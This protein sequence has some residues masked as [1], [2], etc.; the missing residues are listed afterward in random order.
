M[1]ATVQQQQQRQQQQQQRQQQ[2]QQQQQ[3]LHVARCAVDTRGQQV[4]GVRQFQGWSRCPAD[5][6]LKNCTLQLCA[7]GYVWRCTAID[8]G[9]LRSLHSRAWR[10]CRFF[11]CTSLTHGYSMSNCGSTTL[12]GSVIHQSISMTACYP[13]VS[14]LTENASCSFGIQATLAELH[15]YATAAAAGC[16]RCQ[17][18]GCCSA[19]RHPR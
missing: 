1:P 15:P 6:H 19:G 14:H 18:G 9:K 3:Q 5:A 17:A 2:Q 11:S 4:V 8:T 10:L 12:A 13:L 7:A 16:L